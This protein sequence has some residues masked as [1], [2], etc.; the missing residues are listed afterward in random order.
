MSLNVR[1]PRY[2]PT[3]LGAGL[4][5]LESLLVELAR[6]TVVSANVVV[7]LDAREVA[8]V[9]GAGLDLVEPVKVRLDIT[10]L[11]VVLEGDDVAVLGGCADDSEALGIALLALDG[12]GKTDGQESRD[13][14]AQALEVVDHFDDSETMRRYR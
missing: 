1:T 3:H 10:S 12:G 6:V 14:D 11:K 4:D 5:G 8:L 13:E 2:D 7:L 9:Q